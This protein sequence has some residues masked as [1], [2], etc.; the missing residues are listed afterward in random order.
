MVTEEIGFPVRV[1]SPVTVGLGIMTFTV[2]ERKAIL[3]AT[4]DPFFSLLCCGTDRSAV[5][6]K[7]QMFRID[8]SLADGKIQKLLLIKMENERKRILWF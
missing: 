7:S 1:P 4:S 2:T 3:P 6:G 5:P 8:Q